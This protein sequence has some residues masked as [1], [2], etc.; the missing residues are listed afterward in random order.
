MKYNPEK[1]H[2]HSIRL[3]GYDYSAAGAY[4]IT[5]CTYQRECLFGEIMDGE[6]YLN[7][8]GKIVEEE[9]MRSTTIRPEIELDG[10][11]IMPNHMHGIMVITNHN[12]DY[13][14]HNN[15]GAHGGVPLHCVPPR[16]PKSVS[17]FVAGFKSVVTKRINIL[18]DTPGTRVWQRNY[19]ERIIRDELA[20]NNIRRYIQMNPSRWEVD[21]LHRNH[22]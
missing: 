20:L 2:R 7:P 6:M 9:W 18:R 13:N 3:K 19:Y 1:H 4:F 17:S 8:Y 22:A 15:V 10:W 5:L 16:K 11:V 14:V 21:P 12:A